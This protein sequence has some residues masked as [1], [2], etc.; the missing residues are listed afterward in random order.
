[1][2]SGLKTNGPTE[3]TLG[4]QTAPT[5]PKGRKG[6]ILHIF[7]K[8]IRLT[9]EVVDESWE[10]VYLPTEDSIKV[11]PNC[12]DPF[13]TTIHELL[14][15][16]WHRCS[17][18]QASISSEVQEIIVDTMATALSENF[19]KLKQIHKQIGKKR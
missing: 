3:P 19:G 4:S 16:I 9:F 5:E 12:P 7:G 15:A 2:T 8:K 11:S 10:G 13:Q 18:S 14:H 1:M 6:H 17:I